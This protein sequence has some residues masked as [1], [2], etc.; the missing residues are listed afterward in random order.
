MDRFYATKIYKNVIVFGVELN[1]VFD[2]EITKENGEVIMYFDFFRL[3]RP[4]RRNKYITYN[5]QKYTLIWK[6]K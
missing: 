4:D 3:P 6:N 1:D 2:V 5:C